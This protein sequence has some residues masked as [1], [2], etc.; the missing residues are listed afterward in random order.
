M[1]HFYKI[2]LVLHLAL[3]DF[4]IPHQLAHRALLTAKVAQAQLFV[5]TAHQITF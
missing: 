5:Q 1:V 2:I 4:L 3:L